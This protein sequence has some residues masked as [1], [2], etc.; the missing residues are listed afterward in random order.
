MA[1]ILQSI[2][3]FAFLMFVMGAALFLSAGSF[4]FWQAWLYLAVFGGC[5]ILI[6]IY[7]ALYDRDLLAGRVQVGPVAETRPA[8]KVIQSLASLFFVAVYVV[9]GLD[10]RFA[11]SHVLAAVSVVCEL[12]VAVGFLVVFLTF[13][14]NRYTRS[15]IEVSA[16][17]TL[18]STGPYRWVRHPMY[19]GALLLLLFTPPAL[20]SM[21]A[22]PLV[23]PLAAVLVAR[24]GDEEHVLSDTLEGYRD[25]RETV[26]YRLIPFVW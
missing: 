5:T 13:R 19:S 25:Y 22:V 3:G 6:T 16:G 14:E 11:W 4:A 24:I 8:Q 23:L 20:G 26:R 21:V 12:M 2:A 15:T 9:S 1:L 18:V 7:L 17:Q 10:R